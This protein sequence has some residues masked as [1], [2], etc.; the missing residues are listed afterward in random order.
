LIG[1]QKALRT[2]EDEMT[3]S[4]F[5]AAVYDVAIP[6]KCGDPRDESTYALYRGVVWSCPRELTPEQW[7]ILA[8]RFVERE[9]A[10]L[11]SA[12]A[13]GNES[14]VSRERI[15]TEVRRAVWIR[16]QGMCA[17][18][19]SRERLEYDHIVPLARGGSNT[20]RNI[21][22]LCEVCNRAKSDAIM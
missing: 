10:E 6:L 2:I 1:A 5:V 8:D 18:C 19:K 21:E 7:S 22:L 16:Y 4:E 12:L 15:P 14:S 3:T 13:G 17:R 20:E 9:N 11:A